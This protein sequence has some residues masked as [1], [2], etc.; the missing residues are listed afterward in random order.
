MCKFQK[1]S[2]S[3]LK[4]HRRKYKMC[5]TNQAMIECH[6][7]KYQVWLV[8]FLGDQ[9]ILAKYFNRL[10][11]VFLL[12]ELEYTEKY[13]DEEFTNLTIQQRQEVAYHIVSAGSL[14]STMEPGFHFGIVDKQVVM[15]LFEPGNVIQF[16]RFYRPST[17]LT[18]RNWSHISWSYKFFQFSKY[19]EAIFST[20]KHCGIIVG[21]NDNDAT[22]IHEPGN[23]EQKNFNGI[24]F[25]T[26]NFQ[27]G[28]E[29]GEI[30][31]KSA[32]FIIYKCLPQYV[33]GKRCRWATVQTALL[34]LSEPRRYNIIFRNC[35]HF[36]QYCTSDKMENFSSLQIIILI[37]DTIRYLILP[38]VGATVAGYASLSRPLLKVPMAT[39]FAKLVTVGAALTAA[40]LCVVTFA[41]D[42][43]HNDYF[44]RASYD[45]IMRYNMHRWNQKH[46]AKLEK[47]YHPDRVYKSTLEECDSIL[48]AVTE[49][50]MKPP[51]DAA[52]LRIRWQL[53]SKMLPCRLIKS[54]KDAPKIF[55][56][57]RNGIKIRRRLIRDYKAY[58]CS[59]NDGMIL[60][61]SA[62]HFLTVVLYNSI[63]NEGDLVWISY[64]RW[65]RPIWF[66]N[67][68]CLIDILDLVNELL[69]STIYGYPGNESFGYRTVELFP[70]IIYF[71][72]LILSRINRL[73]KTSHFSSEIQ[74]IQAL[75]H[76]EAET[77]LFQSGMLVNTCKLEHDVVR[78]IDLT[79]CTCFVNRGHVFNRAMQSLA[80]IVNIKSNFE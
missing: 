54:L 59:W 75:I 72:S 55:I 6:P 10:K 43:L 57:D 35:E 17:Q 58:V 62:A 47:E 42:S 68:D 38:M 27:L 73:L 36:V 19:L 64:E 48:S 9:S 14:L 40:T 31:N 34:A 49:I 69:K 74:L 22:I 8:V 24:E 37:T 50:K 30:T 56:H 13:L 21:V 45:L 76:P 44:G 15:T 16:M 29:S 20:Y 1:Y 70:A 79:S 2:K 66:D 4:K 11:K 26:L 12:K 67:V 78:S 51:K 41:F 53:L 39:T 23:K 77:K 61:Y 52:D 71:R 63:W 46:Q 25:T 5:I 60:T 7:L 33:F 32:P 28:E 18:R 3:D 65:K 80:D